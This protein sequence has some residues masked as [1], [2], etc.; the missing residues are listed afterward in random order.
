MHSL[1]PLCCCIGI[2]KLQSS[3]LATSAKC[4][5][6]MECNSLRRC[7]AVASTLDSGSKGTGKKGNPSDN[8]K[9]QPKVETLPCAPRHHESRCEICF[10]HRSS[11]LCTRPTIWWLSVVLGLSP[12]PSWIPIHAVFPLRGAFLCR[13]VSLEERRDA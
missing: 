4:C 12:E 7:W 11:V 2:N 3:Q 8:H 9:R 10:S 6:R 5:S 1:K 13:N